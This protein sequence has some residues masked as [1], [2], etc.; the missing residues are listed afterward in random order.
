MAH[1]KQR[2]GRIKDAAP[3]AVTKQQLL[4]HLS[5]GL[6]IAAA[7]RAVNRSESTFKYY[8]KSDAEFATAVARVRTANRTKRDPNAVVDAAIAAAT[9][10]LAGRPEAAPVPDFPEFCERFLGQKLHPHQLQWFD[11]LEGRPPRDLHPAMEYRE[12][13]KTR[14]IVNTPPGHAKSPLALNTRVPT[15]D[16]WATIGD[17]RVG[18]RVFTPDGTPTEVVALSEV[19]TGRD[20]YRIRFEGGQV[21]V[22][23]AEHRWAVERRSTRR[24]S[25]ETTGDMHAALESGDSLYFAL[26]DPLDMLDVDLPLDP[27]LLGLWLGDGHTASGRFTTADPEVVQAF[28]DGG[29]KPRQYA[30]YGFETTGLFR[31]LRLLG[32]I[33]KKY[34]PEG[35]LFASPRQR[36]EL[37]RGLMDSDGTVQSGGRQ[38]S[39]CNTNRDLIDTVVF[40][41]ASLGMKPSVDETASAWRVSW[42]PGE[43]QVF[44]LPR[45]ADKVVLAGRRKKRRILSITPCGSRPT[46][47]IAVNTPDNLFLVG[48][49]CIPTHNTTITVNYV[50][51]RIIQNPSIK[52]IVVSKAQKLAEQFLLQIKERL[53]SDEYAELHAN[54]APPGGWAAESA[55]WSAT[56]FYVSSKVRGAE[57][58]DPT[59]QAIGIRGQVY[60]SRADL[61]VVDDAIDNTNVSDYEKQ[62]TWLLGI[63]GSRLAPR[64]GRLL[65]IG[66]RIAPTDL[67]VEL[68]NPDRYHGG[69]SP[70]TYLKQPAVLE[71]ADLPTGWVTLWPYADNPSDPDEEPM[72][73]GLYRRWDG[74]T[75]SEVRDGL[76]P[77][78]WARIYQQEQVSEQSYFTPE[79]IASVTRGSSPG[80]IP[81]TPMGRPEGM[82]GLKLVAG[83]D[84]AM[85]GF[86]AAVLLGL[87]RQTGKRWVVDVHNQAAMKPDE[88]RTLIKAWTE[89]Y[90]IHEWRVE[91]N[92]F[93]AFLTQDTEIRNYL[94]TRGVVLTDHLTGNNKNDPEFGIAAMTMLFDQNL[95]SLP[96]PHTEAVKAL[97]EQLLTWDPKMAQSKHALRGHKTDLVMALWMAEL[98]CL[99]LVQTGEGSTHVSSMFHTP[100]DRMRQFVVSAEE[101]EMAVRW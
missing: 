28:E 20:C 15:P 48:D 84:P 11:L 76:P 97:R 55:G 17:L 63:V 33:G 78:E 53:T 32:L 13:K 19:F 23:D 99:E 31:E 91:K 96:H 45:K 14:I 12:G 8:V 62:I 2:G 3:A 75:L 61:I 80:L 47:C 16:G 29:F 59:V 68:Q 60:G 58:K 64:S 46:K 94:A 73:S 38:V 43:V 6:S 22:A 44:R 69:T 82:A 42:C 88:I 40:L 52:V 49:H 26:P 1:D 30:E 66:T 51:W 50:I 85:S 95:I 71:Y 27:Y 72:E 87:D 70:W 89:K 56:R 34:T 65:V 83:L 36:L 37:L 18:D 39:F 92:A 77:A 100:R 10:A 101:L 21:V 25:V 24:T 57:A 5:R 79:M 98:R 54:F 4:G 35:Y 7:C 67:Y 41:A 93:Q 90:G 74:E 9:E 86:T 81:R